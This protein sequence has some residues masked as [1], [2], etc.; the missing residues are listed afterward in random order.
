MTSAAGTDRSWISPSKAEFASDLEALLDKAI[1]E[2]R[3]GNL[4]GVVIVRKGKLVLE[5]YFAGDDNTR[6]R[7]LDK[8]AF[9]ADTLHDLR[10]V[11][12]SIVDLLYGIA[13]ADR[14]GAAAGGAARCLL[15]RIRR[16]C[17]RS[18][19]QA[20]DDPHAL[21]MTMGTDW[22]ELGVPYSDPTNSEIAIDMAPDRYRF[23]LGMPVVMDPGKRWVY[24]GGATASLAGIVTRGTGRR[25]HEFARRK[26]FDPVGIGPT[27]W[28]T[29]RD[30]EVIA[31][32]GLRMTPRDL[33]RIGVMMLNGGMWGDRRV[34]AEQWI[35]RSTSAAADVDEI[36]QYGYH[37]YLGKFAFTISTRPR[38]DRSRLERFWG[39]IGNGGQR[40]F[41]FP[42]LDLSAAITAGNYDM[43]DQWV[44][45]TRIIRE[46][47]LAAIT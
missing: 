38:W 10:S 22:D 4:H 1:T 12:K 28:I 47:M 14:K 29:G 27:E 5:R 36:R 20:V 13:L 11:S 39:A 17:S 18:R 3:V 23:I 15:P 41:I 6:G 40:L 45:S 9:R 8:V 26:L 19:S 25:L 24:N 32:S 46:V 44:P 43:P 31:A 7:P 2:K 30:G 21:T 35:A 42:G 33:A 37:W 34:V 16:A